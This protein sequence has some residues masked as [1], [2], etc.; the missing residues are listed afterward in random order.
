M[1]NYSQNI[2]MTECLPNAN[3][4]KT[5]V[6]VHSMIN[7]L[8]SLHKKFSPVI[9]WLF[10]KSLFLKYNFCSIHFFCIVSGSWR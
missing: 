7:L 5:Q 1:E 9:D 3:I 4:K 6:G 8:F 2:Y 10:F